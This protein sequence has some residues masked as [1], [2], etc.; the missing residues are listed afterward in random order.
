ML[1]LEM[2]TQ[3][4]GHSGLERMGAPYTEGVTPP[5][6]GMSGEE[7][8]WTPDGRYVIAG[9]VDGTVCV[10]DVDPPPE[11]VAAWE[12]RPPAGPECTLRPIQQFD[13]HKGRATRVVRFNPRIAMLVTGGAPE[14]AF[15]LPETPSVAVAS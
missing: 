4:T 13:G 2:V 5:R 1:D 7:L 9:S 12:G 14:L 10:W 11:D 6:A 8:S 3:R 15:W